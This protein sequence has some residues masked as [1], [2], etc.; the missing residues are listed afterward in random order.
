MERRSERVSEKLAS[1]RE[2]W[3]QKRAD[4]SVPG[5]PA[6]EHESEDVSPGDEPDS[7]GAEAP[8]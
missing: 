4:P 5:A 1:V 2:D 8:S 7:P 6:P 3:E